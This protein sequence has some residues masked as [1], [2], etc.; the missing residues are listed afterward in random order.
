MTLKKTK[1][2][3]EII[4]YDQIRIL[5]NQISVKHNTGRS[6]NKNMQTLSSRN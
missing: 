1:Y 2:D 3:H 5:N 4:K 6:T